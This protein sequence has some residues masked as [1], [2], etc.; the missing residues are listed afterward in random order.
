MLEILETVKSIKVMKGLASKQGLNSCSMANTTLRQ[1]FSLSCY[2][3]KEEYEVTSGFDLNF[4]L[5]AVVNAVLAV[6]TSTLNIITL[7]V[8]YKAKHLQTPSNF[9]ISGLAI[10]D[11]CT[12]LITFPS[13][14]AVN[15]MLSAHWMS[16]PLRLFLTFAGYFFG[17]C[18]LFSL[19]AI[20]TD[21]YIAVFHPYRYRRLTL[22]RKQIVK[23]HAIMWSVALIMVALSFVSP[24][25]TLYITFI[26]ITLV[27]LLIWSVYTQGKIL[28]ATH[29]ILR[30]ITPLQ[31]VVTPISRV[32]G[33]ENER[34]MLHDVFISHNETH[35]DMGFKSTNVETPRRVTI[36]FAVQPNN[37]D[38]FGTKCNSVDSPTS[39]Y[40]E[41]PV[42]SSPCQATSFKPPSNLSPMVKNGMKPKPYEGIVKVQNL[43]LKPIDRF[44]DI[45][46]ME[47]KQVLRNAK[48][49]FKAVK[50][51]VSIVAAQFIFYI[52]HGIILT[53]YFL[54]PV[55][56]SLHMAHGWTATL[57]L[58]NSTANPIIYCWQ[59]KG[60]ICAAKGLLLCQ[61]R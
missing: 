36:E 10:M 24:K 22:D 30:Q 45:Q 26:V 6:I 18:G 2:Y 9:F 34:Q 20:A 49:N 41:S 28:K 15:F 43:R 54:I 52:P 42:P 19:I 38:I 31:Q 12:G 48:D 25:F 29:K 32:E 58:L 51:T 44:G 7:T 55:T 14:A 5:I 27:F 23:S 39:R 35:K 4:T 61:E 13:H 17:A 56:T 59:L 37:R 3:F 57:S 53:L 16:C 40:L 47:R 60:F 1:E 33:N 8:I 46:K 21:R 50:L 11:T